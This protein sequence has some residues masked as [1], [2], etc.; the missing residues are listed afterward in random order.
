[1]SILL[2]LWSTIIKEDSIT[3]TELGSERQLFY[4]LAVLPE[5]LVAF[6]WAVP[7]LVARVALGSRYHQWRQQQSSGSDTQAA[8]VMDVTDGSKGRHKTE[9]ELVAADAV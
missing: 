5:L 9:A 6:L 4:P 7:T 2:L 8:A 3:H 1:V